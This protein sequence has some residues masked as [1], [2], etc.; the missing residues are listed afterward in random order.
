MKKITKNI[1][2]QKQSIYSFKPELY[3]GAIIT[4]QNIS[5]SYNQDKNIFVYTNKS[6]GSTLEQQNLRHLVNEIYFTDKINFSFYSSTLFNEKYYLKQN[7][8]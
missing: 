5:F 3:Q 2:S 8:K 6:T 4:N 1:F 7:V